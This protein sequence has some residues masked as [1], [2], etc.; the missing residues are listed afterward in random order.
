MKPFSA[1]IF[2]VVTFAALFSGY[3]YWY[4]VVAKESENAARLATEIETKSQATLA[5]QAAQAAIADLAASESS[6]NNYFVSEAQVVPFLEDLQAHGKAAGAN[7]KVS[8][9]S[10]AKVSG[11]PVLVIS[12]QISGPFSAVMSGVGRI[13]YAPYAITTTAFSI[14]KTGGTKEDAW[15]ATLNINVGS[16]AATATPTT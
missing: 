7:V 10:T 15:T 14:G 9:V 12:L 11:H 4:G 13:E 8:S 16:T 5:A 6:I 3:S 2:W 1:L